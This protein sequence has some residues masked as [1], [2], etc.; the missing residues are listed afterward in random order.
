MWSTQKH[1]VPG[2]IQLFDALIFFLYIMCWFKRTY[3]EARRNGE[4]MF[5][6][7]CFSFFLLICCTYEIPF[8]KSYA[9]LLMLFL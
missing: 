3:P 5:L 6:V 7:Y 9:Y 2:I 8:E 1:E 4:Q